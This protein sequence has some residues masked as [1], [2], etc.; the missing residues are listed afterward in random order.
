VIV[1]LGGAFLPRIRLATDRDTD[2]QDV[3]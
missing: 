1:V 3:A 2:W